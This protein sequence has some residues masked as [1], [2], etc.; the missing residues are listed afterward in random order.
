MNSCYHKLRKI[1]PLQL[2]VTFDLASQ[3]RVTFDLQVSG[4]VQTIF[5]TKAF[6]LGIDKPDIRHVVIN[7]VPES[8]LPRI[9]C[10]VELVEM[11]IRLVQ[12]FC[13][14]GQI[15]PMLMAGF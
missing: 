1:L 10:L 8:M 14:D 11:V 12:Q 3:L 13:T 6:G 5:A 7:G 15:F 4:Q 9:K 2:S